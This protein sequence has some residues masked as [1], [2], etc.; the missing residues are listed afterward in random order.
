MRWRVGGAVSLGGPSAA[1]VRGGV[2]GASNCARSRRHALVLPPRHALLM[3]AMRSSQRAARHPARRWS[4]TGAG[5]VSRP[6]PVN[7]LDG[8]V[9]AGDQLLGV[10]EVGVGLVPVGGDPVDQ[11]G[12]GVS[13]RCERGSCRVGQWGSPDWKC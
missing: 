3:S 13:V 8:I 10:G 12:G 11:L 5:G 4:G 6:C 2:A 1:T 7:A 9:E